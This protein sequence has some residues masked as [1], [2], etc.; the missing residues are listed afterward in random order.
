MNFIEKGDKK[1]T[2]MYDSPLVLNDFIIGNIYKGESKGIFLID[3]NKS[4]A[5]AN[6][7]SSENFSHETLSIP[8]YV[9]NDNTIVTYLNID[10]LKA[11]NDKNNLDANVKQHIENGGYT[12]C[13][14]KFET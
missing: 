10:I 6:M 3:T 7:F 12:L 14:F 11:S 2:F 8:L 1:Y 5:Y 4:E 9:M 13:L